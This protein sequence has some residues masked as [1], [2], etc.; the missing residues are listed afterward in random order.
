MTDGAGVGPDGEPRSGEHRGERLSTGVDGLDAILHGGLIPE[1]GYLVRGEPGTGKTLLGLSYLTA[2]VDAGQT[3]LFINLEEARSDI[4]SNAAVFGFDLDG[5]HFL[6]LSPES[7]FFAENR[8]YD[9]FEASDVEYDAMSREITARVTDLEPD[10]VFVDPLTQL[11]YLSSDEYQFRQQA[12]SFMRL[13]GERGAT[14]LFTTQ[15]TPTSPDDDLQ[16]MS[17]GTVEL[18]YASTGQSIRVPKFRGS[19]AESG[20]HAMRITDAGMVVYP[21]L[22]PGT[23]GREFADESVSAGVPGVDE[24]LDGGI[25]RGTVTIISG[26]TGVGKTTTGTQFMKEAAG[27]GE[28]SAVYLFEESESTFFRRSE[29]INIPVTRMVEQGSLSVRE[30][31][32]LRSS[33]QQFADEVRREVEEDGTEIVMIDGISGYR[34]ALRGREDEL[35]THLH[36]L[37]RYLKNMGVTVILI[38]E[39]AKITGEFQATDAGISYLADNILFLQH[40]ELRGEMRKVIGVLKM[41]TSDFERTLREFEITEHGIK[42]GDP[43]TELR[44]ILSGTPELATGRERTDG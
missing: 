7:A 29:A 40:V 44:G 36:A 34:I 20:E 13:L 39:V 41:R 23:H 17:D 11:R 43:L 35:T 14:V 15:S 33:P 18:G 32:A 10:R 1:R 4:E 19:N 5:V 6:D 3:G 42:V 24:L 2:G 38:D 12:L 8:S 21:A 27:R 22:T 25:D 16:F 31:E 30:V 28:R 26:P 37:N 9:V